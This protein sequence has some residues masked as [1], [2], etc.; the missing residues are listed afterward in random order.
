MKDKIK[1]ELKSLIVLLIVGVVAGVVT[2]VFVAFDIIDPPENARE[3]NWWLIGGLIL[4]GAVLFIVPTVILEL[5]KKRNKQIAIEEKDERNLAVRGI[6]AFQAWLFNI[7]LITAV[8][9][10]CVLTGYEPPTL[11]L[12]SIIAIANVVF[13]LAAMVYYQKKM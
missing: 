6:A 11:P 8:I 12:L 1:K 4:G 9:I 10:F 5:A 2:G 3:I 7:G 13:A